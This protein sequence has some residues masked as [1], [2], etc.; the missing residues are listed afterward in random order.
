MSLPSPFQYLDY[1]EFLG[2]WY[3]AKKETNPRFSHRAF[4]RRT[5]QRSPSLLKDVIEGR[6]NLTSAT[7]EAFCHALRLNA[8]ESAFFTALVDLNQARTPKDKNEAWRRIAAT[9]RFMDARRLEGEGFRYLSDWYFPAIRELA[10][11]RDFQPDPAWIAQNLRPRIT[12]KQARD[13]LDL[14][15]DLGLLER[16]ENGTIRPT[17]ASVVTSHHVRGLAVR[18]YHST[19]LARA[20]EAVDTFSGQERHFCSVTASIP[21]PLVPTLKAELDRVQERLLDL[22]DSQEE[23]ADHVIQIN[24]HFF[25]LSTPSD[26][27]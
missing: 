11:C 19:M 25:P 3:A 5:G 23:E 21:L 17:E 1:R 14:L 24:L 10:S 2:R 12:K 26:T 16:D 27:P 18:N 8:S 6:R 4:V 15:L 7:T 20:Q 13:A 22:C 9:R